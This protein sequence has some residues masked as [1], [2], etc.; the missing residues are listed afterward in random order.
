MLGEKEPS[1]AER[2]TLDNVMK[3]VRLWNEVEPFYN[4][5]KHGQGKSR[6]SRATEAVVNVLILASYDARRGSLSDVTR[7]A[8]D[9]AWALQLKSGSNA[10]AWDWQNFHL[11]PW[12]SEESQYNGAAL[13]AVAVGIAPGNLQSDPK[14]QENLR[15]LRAYL[16]REYQTQP[17]LN[18]LVVLWASAKFPGLLT[19]AERGSLMDSVFSQQQEDGGWNLA[20]LGT[21]KRKDNT[22]SETRSDG[23]ATGITVFAMEQAGVSRNQTQ[24][25]KALAW[26]VRSQDKTEGLWPGYSL[27]K[28]RDPAT[29]VGHFMSDAATGYAVLALEQGR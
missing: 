13:F 18:Q 21:W 2:A 27:N 20:K 10:G 23:Y 11:A 22:A 12:E 29:D 7:S 3:R 4:D 6:E 1:A 9:A 28:Q 16:T 19:A 25:K 8:F 17:L 15:L 5:A 24:V 26:L 14:I